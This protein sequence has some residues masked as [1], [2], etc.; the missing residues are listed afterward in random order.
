MPFHTLRDTEISYRIIQGERPAMPT[1]A[2]GLGISDELWNLL[3]Q[4]WHADSKQRPQIHTI[5]RHL[6]NDP[7]RRS[8]FPPSTIPQVPSYESL[9]SNT[10]KYGNSL[11]FKLVP[12]FTYS[13]IGEMFVTASAK[14]PIDG[15]FGV[16]LKITGFNTHV[17]RECTIPPTHKS[18]GIG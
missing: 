7:A 16:S 5:L 10:Q 9:I 18:Y 6:S 2:R 17:I 8:I 13:W 12:W 11:R 1:D 14:T 15:A 4:C 3:T